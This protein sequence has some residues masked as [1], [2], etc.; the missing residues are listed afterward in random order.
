MNGPAQ[1]ELRIAAGWP[2]S[3]WTDETVVVAVSGGADSVA[4]LRALAALRPPAAGGRLI[5]AHLNHGLRGEESD[6]DARFVAELAARL[7]IESVVS[8]GDVALSARER[9]DGVEEAARELRYRFLVDTARSR[10]ARYIATAHTRDDQAETLLQRIVR[11][12]GLAG[13]GGIPR[14]RPLDGDTIGLIRPMLMLRRCEIVE[15]LESIGQPYR[16]DSSNVDRAYTRNRVRHDLLPLLAQ[17]YNPQ[18]VDALSRLAIQAEELR[19]FAAALVEPLL[20]A[21]VT[22]SERGAFELDCTALANQPRYLVREVL[23]TAWNAAGLPLQAM[24]FDEWEALAD[25]ALNGNTAAKRMFP[26]G[27]MVE[28]VGARLVIRQ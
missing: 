22:R 11:G 24:G 18:V 7:G 8:N 1:L 16:I 26:G 15:Y 28:R 6:G 5:A 13:L 17:E 4:L 19:D 23:T 27:V 2:L 20:R 12:T 10:G 25:L 3:R 9:G 21:A 14:V